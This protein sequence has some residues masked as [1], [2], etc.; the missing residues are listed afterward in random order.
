VL[1]AILLF[2]LWFRCGPRVKEMVAYPIGTGTVNIREAEE[3]NETGICAIDLLYAD[4]SDFGNLVERGF[5]RF[6]AVDE[7]T[8]FHA[9]STSNNDFEIDF[10]TVFYLIKCSFL[11]LMTV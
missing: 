7:F 2:S 4:V 9:R 3:G 1:A 8:E 10:Y 5:L 11:G 6:S